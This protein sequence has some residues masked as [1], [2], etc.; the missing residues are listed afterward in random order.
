ML[1]IVLILLLM[2]SS[3]MPASSLPSE[4]SERLKLE[5]RTMTHGGLERTF[6]LYLPPSYDGKSEVPLLFLLHGGGGSG[7]RMV[8]FTGFDKQAV[9]HG[10]IIVCPDG[11]QH[12]WNDGRIGTSRAHKDNV[13]DVGFIAGL[14]DSLS[15]EFKID[16][17]RVYSTG[18]S[19]GA[20]MSYRL[21]LELPDRIAAIGTVVGALP[22]PL[23]K[24]DWS[25]RPV[26][27]IIINGTKDPLVP[28]EGG[29]VRLKMKKLGRVISVPDTARFFARH[30]RC[31]DTPKVSDFQLKSHKSGMKVSKTVYPNCANGAD[32]EFYSI[33]GGGHSWPRDSFFVQYLP[34]AIIGRA[35][36]DFDGTELIWEFF[37]RHKIES[38]K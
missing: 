3:E 14:I 9:E 38:Q 17:S 29:E 16:K 5:K 24:K 26:P 6:N 2:L 10:F 37:T 23:S 28:Y 7:K 19:N 18:I 12:H 11:F 15:K 13:D 36:R 27:A 1:L 35:C 31:G 33:E 32:V 22:E 21:A 30:N 4:G 20:M 34:V 8:N 25:G